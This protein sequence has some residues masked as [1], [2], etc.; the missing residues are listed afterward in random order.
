[1]FFGKQNASPAPVPEG[2]ATSAVPNGVSP[3]LPRG[4]SP[5]LLAA[6][7]GVP[8]ASPTSSTAALA[9]ATSSTATHLI[10]GRGT[11]LSGTIT[12]CDRLVIEGTA[13]V[14]VHQ[15]RVLEIAASGRLIK[16][17]LEVEEAEISGIYEGE[18]TVR[19]RLLVRGSGRVSGTVR[20]GELEIER[21]GQLSG[22]FLPLGGE[23]G[24]GA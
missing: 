4:A 2:T 18:L 23:P 14:T 24:D 9:P 12:G 8:W 19:K 10:V 3:V 6:P 11:S 13:S 22:S 16:G 21:G 15:T 1:M 7:A 5:A 17:K 20:Y